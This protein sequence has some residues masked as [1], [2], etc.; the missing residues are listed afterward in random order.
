MSSS[1][2]VVIPEQNFKAGTYQ[3]TIEVTASFEGLPQTKAVANVK[4]RSTGD[5]KM[6][7]IGVRGASEK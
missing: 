7:C 2:Q 4:G 6:K 1:G 5:S 3:G